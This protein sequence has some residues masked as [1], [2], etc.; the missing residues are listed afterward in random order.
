[1]DKIV[2]HSMRVINVLSQAV[3]NKTKG[4]F[5]AIILPCFLIFGFLAFGNENAERFNSRSLFEKGSTA[6]FFYIWGGGHVGSA[7]PLREINLSK[8][9]SKSSVKARHS[10]IEFLP[11]VTVNRKVVTD[12]EPYK[13][14]SCAEC[15]MRNDA[16]KKVIHNMAD[17][18]VW[19]L[20]CFSL[21]AVLAT[22]LS[23]R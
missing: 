4:Y 20:L 5:A 3:R 15:G 8:S 6:K 11:S 21:G 9:G 12:E 2:V 10:S 18:I 22:I 23:S 14:C 19:C 16:H 13:E 17:R 1:M 7:M